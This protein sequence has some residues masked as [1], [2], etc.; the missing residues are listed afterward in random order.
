MCVNEIISDCVELLFVCLQ[1][2]LYVVC[3][4]MLDDV[5]VYVLFMFCVELTLQMVK[6]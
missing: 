4:T 1:L 3:C 2:F 6:F 5:F